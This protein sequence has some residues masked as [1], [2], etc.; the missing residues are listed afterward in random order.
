M[1]LLLNSYVING[2]MCQTN[3]HRDRI[4]YEAPGGFQHEISFCRCSR[5][6]SEISR[7]RILKPVRVCQACYAILKTQHHP[8]DSAGT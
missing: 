7:L 5:F 1:C 2:F 8:G 6:E 4:N 3:E